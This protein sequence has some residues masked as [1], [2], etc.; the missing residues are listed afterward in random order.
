MKF[1]I[2]I[3]SGTK[4]ILDAYAGNMTYDSAIRKLLTFWIRKNQ[5]LP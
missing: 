2:T 5:A 4:T 1:N 3:D